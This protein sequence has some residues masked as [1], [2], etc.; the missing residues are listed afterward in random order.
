MGGLKTGRAESPQG[1]VRPG[2]RAGRPRRL[3][4]LKGRQGT[5]G[6]KLLGVIGIP[7]AG[8]VW[9]SWMLGLITASTVTS[10]GSRSCLSSVSS[11]SA[12]LRFGKDPRLCHCHPYIDVFSIYLRSLFIYLR[13]WGWAGLDLGTEWNLILPA[14]TV[15]LKIKQEEH[16][17]RCRVGRLPGGGGIQDGP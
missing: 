2:C 11:I 14:L 10:Q 9:K 17:E 16:G 7:V 8:Q 4:L 13:A 12:L 1:Q 15:T 6:P 5:P 3:L